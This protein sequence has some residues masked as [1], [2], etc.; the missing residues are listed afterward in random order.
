MPIRL[1]NLILYSILELSEKLGVTAT[2]IR[3]Y[4]KAGKLRGQK[5][6]AQ[7]YVSEDSL[8]EFF[9]GQPSSLSGRASLPG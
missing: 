1:E 7:W 4:L 9:N 2:T 6:G 8:R 3:A 5:M